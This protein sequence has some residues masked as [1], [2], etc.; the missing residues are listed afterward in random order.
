MANIKKEIESLK[1]KIARLEKEQEKAEQENKAL[2]TANGQITKILKDNGVSF[3]AFVRFHYTRA[4]RVIH[5]IE[6]EANEGAATAKRVAK[7]RTARKGR[8]P[9]NA[10]ATIK[11]PAGEY[12]NLPSNPKQVFAVKE[13]GPRPKALKAYAEEVGLEAF[14]TQC[15]LES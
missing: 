4:S 12:G 2:D 14:L 3:E 10:K 11:I 9:V 15:R 5:R 13:K 8:K 6:G 1:A 7:K